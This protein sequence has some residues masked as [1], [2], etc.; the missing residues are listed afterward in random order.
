MVA[1]FPDVYGDVVYAQTWQVLTLKNCIKPLSYA[2]TAYVLLLHHMA[3]VS[4]RL[5]CKNLGN[6][7]DFFGQMA[8]RPPWQKIA[9]TPMSQN[10][11]ILLLCLRQESYFMT[12]IHFFLETSF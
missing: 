6:L 7:Q 2:S 3:L 11:F 8:Y 4:F 5:F 9:R 1:I 10:L 12:L